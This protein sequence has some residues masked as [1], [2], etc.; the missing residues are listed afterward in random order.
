M[1]FFFS[2]QQKRLRNNVDSVSDDSINQSEKLTPNT[3]A[4]Q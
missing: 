2:P 4:T 3:P 1:L